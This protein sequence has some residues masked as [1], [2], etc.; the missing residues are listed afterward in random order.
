VDV[1]GMCEEN[2]ATTLFGAA[3]GPRGPKVYAWRRRSMSRGRISAAGETTPEVPTVI[4]RSHEAAS[5]TAS[6]KAS[7]GSGSPN[8][9]TPGRTGEPQAPDQ[10]R[11]VVERLGSGQLLRVEARPQAGERVAEG[12]HARLGRHAGPGEHD[13]PLR[14]RQQSGRLGDPLIHAHLCNS[15]TS[16]DRT[17]M[18]DG[19]SAGSREG[20]QPGCSRRIPRRTVTVSTPV[21]F[22][23]PEHQ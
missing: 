21:A 8:H 22:K 11:I 19:T 18:V 1:T 12:R 14:A 13:D 7:S 9:T 3:S 23:Q 17:G 2:H 16:I 5:S 20:G 4:S 15:L 6:A 10:R